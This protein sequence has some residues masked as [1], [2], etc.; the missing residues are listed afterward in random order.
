MARVHYG[1]RVPA[2][3][4]VYYYRVAL[5]YQVKGKFV[6]VGNLAHSGRGDKKPVGLSA[7]N[8]LCIAGDDFDSGFPGGGFHGF[9]ALLD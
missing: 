3:G 9:P 1:Q 4:T 2:H 5:V 7:L 6:S 8:D